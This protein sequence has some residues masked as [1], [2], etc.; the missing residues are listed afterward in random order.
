MVRMSSRDKKPID[1]LVDK[2]TADWKPSKHPPV[3]SVMSDNRSSENQ[4]EA[5]HFLEMEARVRFHPN[6]KKV[7]KGHADAAGAA[8]RLTL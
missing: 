6:N 1:R 2:K 7:K 4:E 3:E 8:H 5:W